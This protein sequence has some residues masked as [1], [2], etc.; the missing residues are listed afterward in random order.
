MAGLANVLFGYV[1][2]FVKFYLKIIKKK[3][4]IFRFISYTENATLYFWVS[5]FLRMF[6]AVGESL[7]A[8]T[9]FPLGN[10]C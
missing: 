1:H 2:N 8:T 9:A 7:V 4:F 3:L 10:F 5:L 6:C